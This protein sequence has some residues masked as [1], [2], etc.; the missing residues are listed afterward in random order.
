MLMQRPESAL[1]SAAT[2]RPTSR[3]IRAALLEV[4]AFSL[5]ACGGSESSTT[6]GPVGTVIV[7]VMDPA[8]TPIGGAAVAL[9][10]AVNSSDPITDDNGEVVFK[11]TLAGEREASA[12]KQGD[13]APTRRFVVTPGSVT[14]LSLIID[15][16]RQP[17]GAR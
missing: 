10:A 17:D 14:R 3:F 4:L 2:A 11:D 5:V 13:F 16:R 7:K 6:H 8:G 9:Y 1:G 12:A 15:R